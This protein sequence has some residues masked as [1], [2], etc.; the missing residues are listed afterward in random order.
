MHAVTPMHN[1]ITAATV[2]FSTPARISLTHP[3][4]TARLL[5]IVK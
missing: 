4:H 2:V 5:R 1:A 3:R